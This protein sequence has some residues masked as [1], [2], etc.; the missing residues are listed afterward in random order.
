[1]ER[2]VSC[3]LHPEAIC[4]IPKM[5]GS[6]WTTE[7]DS[8]SSSPVWPRASGPL[9]FPHFSH[10]LHSAYSTSAN[11]YIPSYNHLLVFFS[12]SKALWCILLIEI[13]IIVTHQAALYGSAD[14]VLVTSYHVVCLFNLHHT[15]GSFKASVPLT[16]L[17]TIAWWEG[18]EREPWWNVVGAGIWFHT[19]YKVIGYHLIVLSVLAEDRNFGLRKQH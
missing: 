8:I 7:E 17:H 10:V 14:I 19:I 12:A 4:T 3:W 16:I 5:G 2:H 18:K 11:F 9:C 1:M 15:S 13:S 6:P